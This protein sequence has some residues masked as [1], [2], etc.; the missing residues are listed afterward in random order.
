[1]TE[2][3]NNIKSEKRRRT[4]IVITF[5]FL[6]QLLFF[7][8]EGLNREFNV[9]Y[10]PIDDLIPFN[11]YFMIP[12]ILWFFYLGFNLIYYIRKADKSTF[13]QYNGLLFGG[14]VFCLVINIIWPSM[15]QLRPTHFE[16]ENVFIEIV[17]YMHVIDTPTNVC[18]S[19]HVYATVVTHMA[20]SKLTDLGKNKWIKSLSF[21]LSVSIL[22]STVFLKQHSIVD[23][24][25]GILV[26]QVIFLFSEEVKKLNIQNLGPLF[27]RGAKERLNLETDSYY[28]RTK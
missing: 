22:M 16:R 14:M 12:Y 19:I 3:L 17:K 10:H 27:N 26:A 4:V 20:L 21:I 8:I 11:E 18:P 28:K 7:L 9:I 15:V 25:I 6:Y 23:V 5:V 2:M 24:V 13:N 1:M